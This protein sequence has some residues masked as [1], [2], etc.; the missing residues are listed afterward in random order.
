MRMT[1]MQIQQATQ[2]RWLGEIPGTIRRLCTDTRKIG[3][4]DVFLA[5]RGPHFN[6]HE[7]GP[8]AAGR[9]ASALIGDAEGVSSWQDIELPQLKVGDGLQALGDI[10]A[11]WRNRIDT[12]IVAITGSVGKTTLR[13]MLEHALKG[14]GLKIAATHANENNLIGVPQTL[15]GISGNEDIALIEC[16]ISE[17]GE[18]ARLAGIVQ[19][20]IAVITAVAHAHTAGLGGIAGVLHEKTA[21]LKTLRPH[22]WCALGPGVASL[23]R[24]HGYELGHPVLDM[25]KEDAG[26]VRWQLSGTHLILHLGNQQAGMELALPASHWAANMALAASITCRLAD[27]TISQATEALSGWQPVSG[28]MQLLA[29]V[30]GSHLIDDTYNANPASMAAALDTLRHLPGRHFAVLGDMAELG[31]GAEQA[32][33]ALDISGLDGVT[34]IGN[35]MQSL[36]DTHPKAVWAADANSATQLCRDWLL[37]N[38]DHVLLKGSRSMGLDAVVRALMEESDAV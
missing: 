1:G 13:S 28:R 33:A 35:H 15:L 24:E 30:G 17:T 2:G 25:D 36:S 27:A 12:K 32:H 23:A 7:F 26:V 21:L 38:S 34:L 20:D 5:L 22:G 9:G 11:A 37:T 19:P 16:G 10:A 31:D 8:V 29:G 6:G 4:D 18:M 14:L 3:N